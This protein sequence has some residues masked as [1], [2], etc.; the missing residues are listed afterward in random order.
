MSRL[1]WLV[2]AV[3]IIAGAGW[4][5]LHGDEVGEITGPALTG[6]QRAVAVEVAPVS[7]GPIRQ[8][9]SFTGSLTAAAQ[10]DVSTRIGGRL[11]ELL[12]DLGDTVE[13]GQ[14]I[15][16]LDDEEVTQDLAQA[17]AELAVARANLAE[18][19]ASLEAA[20]RSLGRIQE[21]R[22][23]RVASQAE[24]D[25]AATDVRAHEARV[26]LARSQIAQRE[27]AL[28]TAE[29]RLSYTTVRAT[30]Q[31]ADDTRLVAERYADEGTIL[32]ANNPIVSLVALDPLRAVVF[33]TEAD[34][35]RLHTGQ[36]AEITSDAL[37][38]RRFAGEIQRLAPVFREASRQ[39]RVEIRVP[40]VDGLLKPGMFVQ[41][42][43]QVDARDRAQRIPL[44]ALVERDGRRGVFLV[45]HEA[46][47]A[48]WVPVETGLREDD[49]VEIR[50]PSLEGR[51][52]TLG[53]HLLADGGRVSIPGDNGARQ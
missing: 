5:W 2:L 31:G 28:R 9:T 46:D 39:A 8:W 45:A 16:R 26:D 19:E 7:H 20:R 17:R 47:T 14:V 6:Q 35:M 44:D 41:A 34:Y 33:A 4:W 13:R 25:A 37:P 11:E 51:V 22:E 49:Y 12:A 30:W 36:A 1:A 32:Q 53:Q 43:I 18:A 42:R 21:L 40:N 3:A 38:G 52:V 48:R 27:A 50:Q 24:L 29:I 15:A 10:F 23:Q